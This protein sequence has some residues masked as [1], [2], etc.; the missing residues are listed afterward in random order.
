M[1]SWGQGQGFDPYKGQLDLLFSTRMCTLDQK[2][3]PLRVV[4]S[5]AESYFHYWKQKQKQQKQKHLRYIPEKF[6]VG[7]AIFV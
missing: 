5:L 3:D 1:Y 2:E 6:W 4:D 7:R